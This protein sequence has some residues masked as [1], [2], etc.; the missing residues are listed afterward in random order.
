MDKISNFYENNV[1]TL[2]EGIDISNNKYGVYLLATKKFKKGE[3]VFLFKCVTEYLKNIK[4]ENQ[5][6]KINNKGNLQK[7]NIEI[8]LHYSGVKNNTCM[9]TDFDCLMNHSCMPNIEHDENDITI[10]STNNVT[11]HK[12]YALKTINIGDELTCNYQ[13]VYYKLDTPFDCLCGNAK[14]HKK[15]KGMKYL[16]LI[17]KIKL[18]ICPINDHYKYKIIKDVFINKYTIAIA[19]GITTTI[20]FFIK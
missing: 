5:V 17:E 12:C 4:K 19:I 20:V 6:L 14:C 10:D 9:I 16:T 8:F 13:K 11:T 18:I 7:Y 3:T 1:F 2:P 15:I